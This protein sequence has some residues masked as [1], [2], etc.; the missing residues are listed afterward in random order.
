MAFEKLFATPLNKT[1][2]EEK[3]VL[4]NKYLKSCLLGEFNVYLYGSAAKYSMTSKS[5]IDVIVTIKDPFDL[6]QSKKRYYSGHTRLNFPVDIL[7][8]PMNIFN[9]QKNIGGVCMI[10]Y[11][12]GIMLK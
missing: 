12:E 10:A 9:E 3:I 5:D 4:L 1:E 6:K 2:I 7:F 11:S 8:I